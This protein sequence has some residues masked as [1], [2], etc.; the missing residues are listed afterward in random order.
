MRR[1]VILS[2]LG[3]LLFVA[4]APPAL[5][6]GARARVGAQVVFSGGLDIAAGQRADTVVVFHGPVRID[7]DV[8]GSAVVFD[9]SFTL[10]GTV[11]DNVFV[12]NG[13]VNLQSGA[14]VGGDLV[15]RQ[16][17]VIDPGATVGGEIKR[18]RNLSVSLGLAWH[19][20]LWI[21]YTISTLILGLILLAL[22]PRALEAAAVAART[23]IGS[24]IG[25]GLALFFGLPL[26]GVILL[27][28]V[29]GIPLGIALLLA[30]WLVYT[31]GYTSA[32]AAVG[33]AVVREPRSKFVAFLAGWGIMRLLAVIPFLGGVL[34]FAGAVYGLGALVAAASSARRAPV[35]IPPPPP[36]PAPST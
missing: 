21:A 23:R 17:P 12:F 18:L 13:R 27:A 35:G 19:W 8:Q 30:L 33:R 31:I 22:A 6:A 36:V 32:L 15:T 29:V 11:R 4:T 16:K 26:V 10:S 5:A 9:G 14:R 1:A 28:T 24:S 7:G 2:F 25:W 34:W 20:A 3:L